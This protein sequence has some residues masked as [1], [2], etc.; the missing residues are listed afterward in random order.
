MKFQDTTL[1]AMHF[2]RCVLSEPELDQLQ[3]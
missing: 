3:L 1:F 2:M